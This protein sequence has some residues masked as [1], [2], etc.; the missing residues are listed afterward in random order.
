MTQDSLELEKLTPQVIRLLKRRERTIPELLDHLKI[1]PSLLQDL[2]IRLGRSHPGISRSGDRIFIDDARYQEVIP[3]RHTIE[4]CG[5]FG[6]ISCTHFGSKYAQ[7][8]ALHKYYQKCKDHGVDTVFHCGDLVDGE[9]VYRGQRFEQHLQGFKD[10]R[11]FTVANYPKI[12]GIKTYIIAGN[13]DDSLLTYANIDVVA[14]IVLQREDM[15][16]LGRYGAY[17]LLNGVIIAKLHHGGPGGQAYARSYK[18]Q[19]FVESFTSENKPQL[20]FLGHYHT[21]FQDFLRN[22]HCFQVACF[23]GQTPYLVRKGLDPQITGW[24]IEYD[25][26]TKDGWSIEEATVRLIPSYRE[27]KDDWK[28]FV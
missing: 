11:D 13:H 3:L 24:I 14:E 28:H 26:S 25:V 1:A 23:Q 16:Y 12:E 20:Y 2:L 22:I 19:K 18:M 21:N 5:K 4:T 9:R 10:Q 27:I 7:I 15:D 6:V 8:T 17:V